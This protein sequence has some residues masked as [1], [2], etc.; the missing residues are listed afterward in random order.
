MGASGS[1]KRG[2]P[3]QDPA[4]VQLA[5]KRPIFQVKAVIGQAFS[6]NPAAV[7]PLEQW[8][9]DDVR[10]R[11]AMENAVAETAFF[12]QVDQGLAI[13]SF[14]RNS[15]AECGIVRAE[16]GIEKPTTCAFQRFEGS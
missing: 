4:A 6:G 7:C 14:S 15:T 10:Q 2:E 12:V 11:I 5:I 16:C 1:D 3:Q 13:R 9:P 8:L